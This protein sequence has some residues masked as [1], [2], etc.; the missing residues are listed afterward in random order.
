[1]IVDLSDSPAGRFC[2]RLAALAGD[3][4]V[5]LRPSGR[6]N[7]AGVN[8]QRLSIREAYLADGVVEVAVEWSKRDDRSL[9]AP[10]LT[11]ADAVI[12]SFYKGGFAA[13]FDDEGVR[14]L[15]PGAVHVIVS[16][17]GIEGPYRDYA[18][19][20]LIDWAAG[21]Y[22]Y[23]TGDPEKPPLPGPR[24]LCAYATGYMAAIAMEA[25]L[26]QARSGGPAC[27]LDVSYM[28]TMSSLHQSAFPRLASGELMTR[29]G[30]VVGPATYPH[31]SYPCGDRELFLGI[32][33]DEEWDR[34]VIA[35][36]RPELCND[37][38]LATGAARKANADL[39]DGIV[40][41]WTRHQ[42]VAEAAAAF[43]QERRV[44][45]TACPTPEDLLRDSQLE[46]RHYFR[47]A[48][49][50]PGRVA[51]RVP[52]N[53]VP[54]QRI[55]NNGIDEGR[56]ARKPANQLVA[57]APS[58]AVLPLAGVTVLDM[59]LWWAGP[60]AARILGDLGA[61]VIRIERPTRPADDNAWPS[62]HRFVHEQMHRNKRSIVVDL[63]TPEGLE[64]V[65][66]LISRVD[67]FI[68]NY[69]PG[70]MERL[71][72]DWKSALEANP[73]LV[74]V[75][76]SGYG[77]EGPKSGWGTYG[78]LSEAAS[79]VRALTHYPG[80]GGM[81]LGDQ[82]PDAVCGLVG[83]LAAL[84]GL[85]ERCR[86]DSGCHFDISQLEAY[87]A[88]IGEEIAAASLRPDGVEADGG[89]LDQLDQLDGVFRCR[90]TD[91]WVAVT[92]PDPE[93]ASQMEALLSDEMGVEAGRALTDILEDF[94]AGRT[95]QSVAE[96]LQTRGIP[97]FPVCTARDL[98]KDAHLRSRHY[99]YRASL[100]GVSASLP[101]SPIRA[102]PRPVVQMR[103]PAPV[104][105]E[106]SVEI[107]RDEVS[108]SEEEVDRLLKAGVVRQRAR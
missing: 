105:G 11:G 13:P 78:T 101:G 69:R 1:M 24:D 73:S 44:P 21:G 27:T 67:V 43:L 40:T 68:Q 84:R 28:E 10:Y 53:V 49:L 62:W 3:E 50:G 39:A 70:V 14:R 64:V 12:S 9:V 93:S 52:G 45:A 41:S 88:L 2:A 7:L 30:N 97:A 20:S 85:R 83:A 65:Q 51:G 96:F 26:A 8:A 34:F 87:V 71:G 36:G 106:H 6:T 18:S 99:F 38:R 23:I 82:L 33:T 47:G 86:T 92:V 72:L 94:A 108:L 57:P 22:L 25:G 32:V 66:R 58:M 80:E 98:V 90:G 103:R 61:N 89:A 76:L 31:R 91:E 107:L 55:G 16:P 104:A 102:K 42:G 17:F 75:S 81:R 54:V 77:S 5:R 74:Y 19:S 59:S 15:N 56:S 60:M 46:Y 79:A 4:V 63:T 35:V 48:T 37:P 95:K 29:A 100:G